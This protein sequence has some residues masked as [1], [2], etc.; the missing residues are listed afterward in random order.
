MPAWRGIDAFH[1]LP[2]AFRR[3]LQSATRLDFAFSMLWPSDNKQLPD[4]LSL[5]LTQ[6][7]HVIPIGFGYI[8]TTA[9]YQNAWSSFL[10]KPAGKTKNVGTRKSKML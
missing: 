4:E 5:N 3:F 1:Q 7:G 8:V 2:C 10:E 9:N 6:I